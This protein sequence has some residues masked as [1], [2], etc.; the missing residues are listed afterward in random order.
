MF[1][2]SNRNFARKQ[3]LKCITFKGLLV[4]H[5]MQLNVI[6]NIL[7]GVKYCVCLETLSLLISYDSTQTL[8]A[9]WVAWKVFLFQP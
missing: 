2:G 7:R 5:Y 1:S 6:L 8:A 4:K 9:L 3:L